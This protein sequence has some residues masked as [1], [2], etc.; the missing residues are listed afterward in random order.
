VEECCYL[1]ASN[2]WAVVGMRITGALWSGFIATL[3]NNTDKGIHLHHSKEY[4]STGLTCLTQANIGSK[5]FIMAGAMNGEVLVFQDEN[6]ENPQVLSNV[7]YHP[8]SSVKYSH[9]QLITAGWD[10][11]IHLYSI[12]DNA[13]FEFVKR[14]MAHY[15]NINN[16]GWHR[17]GVMFA[18]CG[19][20]GDLKCWD[21]RNSSKPTS[22]Y[23]TEG[24]LFTLDWSPANINEIAIGT[25]D[26]IQIVDIR[27]L[28]KPLKT[29]LLSQTVKSL[30]YHPTGQYIAVGT[31]EDTSVF[32]NAF[33]KIF[34]RN[35]NHMVR[36][37]R[38]SQQDMNI[39]EY[40]CAGQFNNQYQIE[41]QLLLISVN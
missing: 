17:D 29:N 1:P 18:S 11:R 35:L 33:K 16:L 10:K 9:N 4:Q 3:Q 19:Q 28:D 15:K 39:R 6:F 7:H 38:W 37:V 2:R 25:Q 20:D 8:V 14:T 40:L 26:S 13:K 22:T 27:S 31:N 41:P 5:N 23:S 12:K 36:S 21:S 30:S 32:D 24:P 34:S